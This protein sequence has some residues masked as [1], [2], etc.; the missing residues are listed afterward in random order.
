MYV[1]AAAV[2][3]RAQLERRAA[4][5]VLGPATA[6]SAEL[7]IAV[8]VELIQRVELTPAEVL[9]RLSRRGVSASESDVQRVFDQYDLHPVKR[10][11]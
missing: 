7:A 11:L 6:V 10:G 3:Q 2:Q 4:C 1:S 8:L 5:S 9:I